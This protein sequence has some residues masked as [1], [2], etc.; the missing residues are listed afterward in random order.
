MHQYIGDFYRCAQY[1]FAHSC[2]GCR[3]NL[4]GHIFFCQQHFSVVWVADKNNTISNPLLTSPSLQL[5]VHRPTTLHVQTSYWPTPFRLQ[6]I[7]D[8]QLETFQRMIFLGLV[9]LLLWTPTFTSQ[10]DFA[11]RTPYLFTNIC[12][13]LFLARTSR[14]RELAHATLTWDAQ[15]SC[16]ETISANV[17][18]DAY[19]INHQQRLAC[20]PR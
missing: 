1:L 3:V 6:N 12:V 17:L 20:P 8:L 19:L 15:K 18:S 13:T 16:T 2:T 10:F 14:T 9:H 4:P 5:F 11:S 7:A